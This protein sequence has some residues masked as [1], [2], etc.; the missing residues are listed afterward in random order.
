[1]KHDFWL[2]RLKKETSNGRR[3]SQDQNVGMF[4]I[5]AHEGLKKGPKMKNSSKR[6]K[7]SIFHFS[8]IF[9]E[10]SNPPSEDW[11][12]NQEFSFIH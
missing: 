2:V 6:M 11:L 3:S 4:V 9:F 12:L 10:V 5:P 7:V 1:M 8:I